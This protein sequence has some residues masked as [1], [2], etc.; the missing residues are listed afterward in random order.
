M[1]VTSMFR[2]TSGADVG[3]LKRWGA[4]RI[5]NKGEPS[6]VGGHVSEN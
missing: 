6:M 2:L 1:D 4:L 5:S 3:I